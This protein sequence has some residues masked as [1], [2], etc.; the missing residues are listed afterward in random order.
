MISLTFVVATVF[1]LTALLILK[2]NA[3]RKIG[4]TPKDIET[5][6]RINIESPELIKR[7]DI[8]CSALFPLSFII[9]NSIY[10]SLMM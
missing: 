5:A 6:Q 7:I 3:D 9:I 4:Q 1:E 8:I 10:M 2:Q